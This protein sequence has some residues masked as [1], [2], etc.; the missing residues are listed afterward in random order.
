[1]EEERNK[2][3]F[4][5]AHPELEEALFRL[6]DHTL[7][8]GSVAAFELDA[9]TFGRRS[10]AFLEVFSEDDSVPLLEVSAALLAC[11]DY[12]QRKGSNRFQFGSWRRKDVWRQLFTGT[13]SSDFSNTSGAL[14]RLLDAIGEAADGPIRTRL[15]G[16]VSAYVAEQ[17]SAGRFDWRYYLVNY[18]E[19]RMGDSGLYV[20]PEAAGRAL[21]CA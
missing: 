10:A 21:I 15:R 2:T 7:N 11:G 18:D 12:S 14:M 6:E 19:M 8:R 1:M 16:V 4:L 5:S 13:S 3:T 9:A 17:V 20:G